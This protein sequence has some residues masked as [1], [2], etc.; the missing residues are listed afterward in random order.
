MLIIEVV[1]LL[2]SHPPCQRRG[3]A[4]CCTSTCIRQPPPRPPPPPIAMAILRSLTTII[5]SYNY[6]AHR[7]VLLV[8]LLLYSKDH[9]SAT[10][11]GKAPFTM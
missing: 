8:P 1:N 10:P 9:K 5:R 2:L 4:H 11:P 7:G 3:G 6:Y